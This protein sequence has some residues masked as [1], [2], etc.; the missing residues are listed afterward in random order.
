MAND[1]IELQ[2]YESLLRDA[3]RA[4]LCV[5][6]LVRTPPQL[7]AATIE[8]ITEELRAGLQAIAAVRGQLKPGSVRASKHALQAIADEFDRQ[9]TSLPTTDQ[10]HEE[11]RRLHSINGDPS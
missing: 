8:A 10:E 5:N 9:A 7:P 1:R 6:A 11:P 3:E 4:M 2:R